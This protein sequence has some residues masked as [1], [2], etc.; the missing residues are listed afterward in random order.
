MNK[1]ILVAGLLGIIGNAQANYSMLYPL[2]INK[3]GTLPNGTITVIPKPAPPAPVPEPPKEECR[4]LNQNGKSNHWQVGS[5]SFNL[6]RI[7]WDNV[8]VSVGGPYT[9]T[10]IKVGEYTYTR[11]AFLSG[12]SPV[13]YYGVCRIL[14]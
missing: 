11:G 10:T 9:L 4:T 5:P 8:Q 13:V 3:G 12:G 6:Y 1:L 2:E 14:K 7:Y